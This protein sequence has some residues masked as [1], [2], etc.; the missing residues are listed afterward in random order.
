VALTQWLDDALQNMQ[1][2]LPQRVTILIIRGPVWEPSRTAPSWTWVNQTLAPPS[3]YLATRQYAQWT[4]G[5]E[6]LKLVRDKWQGRVV[7]EPLLL[8]YPDMKAKGRLDCIELPLSWK[9]TPVEKRC[10]EDA[11]RVAS[12]NGGLSHVRLP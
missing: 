2:P 6:A 5:M 11:W 12:E 1:A 8:E 4:G 10:I 9:L 3:A 7:I